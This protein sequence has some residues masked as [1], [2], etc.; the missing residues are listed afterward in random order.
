MDGRDLF[1]EQHAAVHSAA[2]GGEFRPMQAEEIEE[3]FGSPA[4][5]LGPIGSESRHYKGLKAKVFVDRALLGRKNLIAGANKE[6]YHL[7]NVTPGLDFFVAEEQ[8]ADLR[9][10]EEGEAC[11]NCGQMRLPHTVCPNCGQY[12]G[13][14]VVEVEK[15]K[16]K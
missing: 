6:N 15:E 9:L 12:K 1:L 5:Y 3:V 11:P 14:E 13:R 10:V 4:G 8:W 7:R 2:V 16:K